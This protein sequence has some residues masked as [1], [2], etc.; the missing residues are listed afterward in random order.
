M[1][2]WIDVVRANW[3]NPSMNALR[4]FGRKTWQRLPDSSDPALV[5]SGQSVPP[6]VNGFVIRAR[7]GWAFNQSDVRASFDTLP[8]VSGTATANRYRKPL[9]KTATGTGW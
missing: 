7:Q 4:S 1:D 6:I 5:P 2:E 8:F 3:P 9:P